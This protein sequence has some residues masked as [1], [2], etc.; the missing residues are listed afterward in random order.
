MT[1]FGQRL[2]PYYTVST[3]F[4]LMEQSHI[5]FSSR[6]LFVSLKYSIYIALV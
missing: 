5:D 6:L 1:L 4:I 3:Q 2:V